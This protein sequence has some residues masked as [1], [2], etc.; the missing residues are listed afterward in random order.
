[1]H[2]LY[3]LVLSIG[4]TLSVSTYASGQKGGGAGNGGSHWGYDGEE[5]AEHWGR[6]G[7]PICSR[8]KN[9]SPVDLGNS[10]SVALDDIRFDYHGSRLK[11]INNGHTV[12]FNYD[13]GSAISVGG[14]RY[15]LLQFHF[16][17]P[18]E[19]T[20][21]GVP[22]DME[23]HLVHKSADNQ[24]AV[25]GVFIKVGQTDD[26]DKGHDKGRNA[27]LS[28]VFEAFPE[29]TSQTKTGK[30]PINAAQLLPQNQT[31]YHFLGSLTTP[32]CTE[33][34]N[35]FVMQN[36]IEITTK[37]L[38]RFTSIFDHNARPIQPWNK[39]ILFGNTGKGGTTSGDSSGTGH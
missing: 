22:F 5:G 27:S 6:L 1:M 14:K 11:S 3:L 12:Q 35:W 9:Q 21:N 38:S 33:G 16:H 31:Y 26:R 24:L 7:Y 15:A 18:S 30:G 2:V 13:P 17:S 32:P 37:Q 25:V 28:S 23:M 29:K 39:R 19:N 34:V 4:L 20:I 10:V 8:G 36:P